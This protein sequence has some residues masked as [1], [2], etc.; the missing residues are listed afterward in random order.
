MGFGATASVRYERLY[1]ATINSAP[2]A[3]LAAEVATS[4]VGRDHVLRD[5]E[6]SMGAEDFA[7]MLQVKPG[8]YLRVGQGAENGIGSC[9]LHN[10]RYDFNDEILPLGAALHASLIEHLMPLTGVDAS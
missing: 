7:F 6:P 10:S 4:L 2:E 3:Q 9:S 1:P 8:A 5:L